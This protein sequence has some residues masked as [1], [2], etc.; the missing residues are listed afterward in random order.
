MST[1]LSDLCLLACHFN[2][3]KESFALINLLALEIRTIH[4]I[5]FSC[6]R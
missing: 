2:D 3:Y 5:V 6:C 4:V 1:V